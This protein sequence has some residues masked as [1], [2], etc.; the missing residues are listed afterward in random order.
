MLKEEVGG[1]V[2]SLLRL[3]TEEVEETARSLFKVKRGEGEIAV[4]VEEVNRIP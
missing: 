2:I 4:E 3:N 1:D